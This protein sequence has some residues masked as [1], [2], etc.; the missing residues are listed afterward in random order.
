MESIESL[1]K[2]M[3]DLGIEKGVDHPEVLKLS[4]QL[5]QLLNLYQRN[6]EKK[7]RGGGEA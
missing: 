5:D 3:I 4:K 7:E 6:K 2:K 1:R